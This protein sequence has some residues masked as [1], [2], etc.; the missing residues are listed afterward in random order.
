[1][2][3]A[4]KV[5][6]IDDDAGPR[7]S[8]KMI[9]KDRYPVQT[10]SSALEGLKLLS[11][12]EIS[13][14]LLDLRMPQMDGITALQEIKRMR[15]DAE[16]L[17]VTAYA[18]VETARKAIQYGAFDYLLKPF[19]KNDVLKAV[20]KG[21]HKRIKAQ[22]IEKEHSELKDLVDERTRD[23]TI[24]EKLRKE[25]FNHATDG[26]VIMS[27][28]G[29]FLDLNPRACEMLGYTIG[30]LLGE[31][32]A[33][34]EGDEAAGQWRK[35][36]AWLSTGRPLLFEAEHRTKTGDR[37]SLEVSAKMIEMD[38]GQIIQAFCRDITEKKRLREQLLRTQKMESIGTLAGGMAHDFN[39]ILTAILGQTE[40]ILTYDKET[41]TESVLNK[42]EVIET[43]AQH[44]SQVVSQLLSFSRRGNSEFTSLH[45]NEAVEAAAAMVSKLLNPKIALR[46]NFSPSVHIMKGNGTQIGQVI[47]NL[48][49][50]ARDAMPDGGTI[51]ITTDMVDSRQD[52]LLPGLLNGR[53]SPD[54]QLEGPFVR[55]RVADTG[56]GMDEA[57]KARAFEP[58][59]TTKETGKGTGLGLAAVYGIVKNHGGEIVLESAKGR[60]TVFTLYFPA[61]KSS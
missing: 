44:A 21:M 49:I 60:G 59:F 51:T 22:E 50:N 47:M 19:D 8:L 54:G 7:E 31:S 26:I 35:H 57:T 52:R 48:I 4:T 27:A 25:L 24:A 13:V 33:L 10:A 58:F 61:L 18:S 16:V 2:S 34:L 56:I 38:G 15:P 32:I 12:D 29:M 46:N 43:A 11:Q 14:I 40:M 6:I 23:L 39:N 3:T 17:I 5:L 41:L 42:L 45:I 37:I 53:Y 9:I 55:V 30:E 36:L 28:D 1:M 20:E